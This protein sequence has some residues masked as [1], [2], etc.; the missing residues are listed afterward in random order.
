MI[1][2]M[3]TLKVSVV[4]VCFNEENNIKHCLD[5][6]LKQG[7][8]NYEIVIVDGDSTDGTVR[9]VSEYQAYYKNV[10]IIINP[11]RTI[12]SNRNVGVKHA[13]GMLVA[14]TDADCIVPTN[15]LSI[16]VQGYI[17]HK[18][19]NHRI[20]AVGG[21][22]TPPANTT[23]FLTALG[24]LQNTFLGSLG[25]VQGKRYKKPHIVRSLSTLNV[26][27]ERDKIE[28]IGLFDE[29]LKN[30]CEDADINYRLTKKGYHLLYLPDSFVIHKFRPTLKKWAQNMF[31]YGKG[32]ARLMKKYRTITNV[33]YLLPL[34][35]ILIML[36][37]V[38]SI[39]HQLFLIPLLYFL[40]I[41]LFSV[42][43]SLKANRFLLTPYIMCIYIVQHFAYAAGEVYGFIISYGINNALRL[44]K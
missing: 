24:I 8:S 41:G 22:N 2:G 34:F 40:T 15:W 37:T 23:D 25:S 10:K 3:K 9:I 1:S 28:E 42:Y 26:L 44:S 4:V 5:S 43:I 39:V 32:R 29:T 7:Y 33:L 20:V 27:Y 14:F 35:F 38:L 21:G 18:G 12:A 11:K 6:I 13:K 31:A 17:R 30:M 36:S 19:E 16:L